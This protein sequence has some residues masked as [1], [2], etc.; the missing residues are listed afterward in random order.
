MNTSELLVWGCMMGG[1]LTIALV[2]LADLLMSRSVA[3]VRAMVFVLMLGSTSLLMTSLPAV[4]FPSLSPLALL[5][6]QASLGPLCGAVSL[7]YLALWLGAAVEDRLVHYLLSWGAVAQL[8]I[9]AAIAGW[10]VLT[11]GGEPT[12]YLEVG[13][14]ATAV[15]VSMALAATVRANFL[16]DQLAGWMTLACVFLAGMVLGLYAYRLAPAR[17]DWPTMALAAFC[18]VGH[19][20]VVTALAVRR[21]RQ[22]RQLQRL[23]GLAR[24]ADPATG[25]A[26]GSVLL[27]KVDDAFWRSARRNGQCTVVCLHLSNLYELGEQAGHSVD[28]QILS[29]VTARIRRAVGFRC[30]VGLYHPRCFVLVIS[31]LQQE[32][33][34]LRSLDRLKMVLSKPLSVVGLDEAFHVFTPRY[35]LGVVTVMAATADPI[36][37]VDQA[38]RLSLQGAPQP[39]T[40][41]A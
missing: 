37:V 31:G 12:R 32:P 13:A 16:G 38:E 10:V 23:A 9:A 7:A 20:L 14:V 24:G 35:Q 39:G 4:I 21:N 11:G 33:L 34:V 22:N 6:L 27:S 19:F 25:L 2:A 1:L 18:T 36:A 17:F 3:S 41:A 40:A 29:A 30:V 5:T 28:Q 8:G 15:G 26:T